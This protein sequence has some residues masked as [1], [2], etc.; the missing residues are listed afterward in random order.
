MRTINYA[1]DLGTT[2]SL[3]SRSENGEVRVFKNPFGQREELPSVVG[4][5][6]ERILIGDKALEYLEKDPG[7]VFGG[8]K[9]K[10]GTDENF[11][12]ESQAR[13][14]S[15]IELST[16]VLKEL[17]NFVQD[18]KS[19]NQVVIT[20]PASFDTVQSNATKKAGH[21]SGFTNVVL[22]QEPIAACL[23]FANTHKDVD[24]KG[25]WLV[26]DLGG[27]TFDVAIVS[28]GEEELKVIDH[29]GDNYLGGMDFDNAIVEK[30]LLPKI[31][32]IEGCSGWQAKSEQKTSDFQ[33]LYFIL[34]NKAESIKKELSGSPVAMLD[35]TILNDNGEEIDLYFDVTRDQFNEVITDKVNYSMSL[36]DDLLKV[37]DLSIKDI[38]QVVLV[39]G[40]TLVPLVKQSIENKLGASVNQSVDPTNAVVVGAAHYAGTKIAIAEKSSEINTTSEIEKSSFNVELSY[41]KATREICE[42]VLL[43]FSGE[44]NGMNYRIVRSDKGFDSGLK[45]AGPKSMEMVN[46]IPNVANHFEV[47]FFNADQSPIEGHSKE[48]MIVHGQYNVDGQPLP[49]DICLEID[50]FDYDRT[51]LETIFKKND[52]LPLKKRLYRELSKTILKS[53][54]DSLI[55]NVVEGNGNSSPSSNQVI[56][57]IEVKSEE[58]DF[59]LIKGTEVEIDIEVSESR[60]LTVSVFLSM[61]DQE[62]KEVFSPTSRNVSI[63]RLKEEV[64]L[65]S[66]KVES[67]FR[68]LESTE[69]YE[70]LQKV[71]DM[72]DELSEIS[73]QLKTAEN[74][75]NSDLKYHLEERKR[76]VAQKYDTLESA[77]KGS[78]EKSR[79]LEEKQYTLELFEKHPDIDRRFRSKFDQIT[80]TE[81]DMM[82][83]DMAHF[84]RVKAD[85][86]ST[87]NHDIG[88]ESGE[89]VANIFFYYKHVYLE[90]YLD[91]KKAEKLIEA[92]DEAIDKDR[93]SEVK[94]ILHQLHGLLP[95]E[96]KE[97]VTIQ[98]TGLG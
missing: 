42:M 88:W 3:I 79:Y 7:N 25:K 9:R 78:V 47:L 15:A 69:N 60:D 97:K 49:N 36:V 98:G 62:F 68:S 41:L 46:L 91:R 12:I 21:D 61:T 83:S 17:K 85:E 65:L 92:G 55:I 43:K 70:Q 51:K 19:I 52:I 24:K 38:E 93:M 45:S 27:G 74:S 63:S 16:I 95:K 64:Q 28:I 81:E 6:G 44:F 11:W 89:N 57:C 40:S 29:K 59:D 2:N 73:E 26:Y 87:L 53:G 39:G 10:M 86:L 1:I 75:M 76:K 22:L 80:S 8:F 23:A 48:M 32:S 18:D 72:R 31:I 37:N 84:A 90:K 66:R 94:S 33:K 50:D 30:I 82:K 4:F 67:E 54:S 5:R 58:L 14:I 13:T 71:V 35:L 56:G 34:L 77:G 96:E 20:I